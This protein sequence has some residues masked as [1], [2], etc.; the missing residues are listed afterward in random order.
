M[1]IWPRA[2]VIHGCLTP[3]RSIS[4]ATLQLGLRFDDSIHLVQ[5]HWVLSIFHDKFMMK[6]LRLG[7]RSHRIVDV[8]QF[9]FSYDELVGMNEEISL[10]QA[11]NLARDV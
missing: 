7:T 9:F 6:I 2:A 10:R 11:S 4:I 1:V 5:N 8:K 3:V